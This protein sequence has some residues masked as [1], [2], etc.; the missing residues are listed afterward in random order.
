MIGWYRAL[1]TESRSLPELSDHSWRIDV[2]VKSVG[3]LGTYRKSAES[4]LWFTGRH[5]AH[6]RGV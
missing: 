5:S 3:W 6:I 2:V 1:V 4:G